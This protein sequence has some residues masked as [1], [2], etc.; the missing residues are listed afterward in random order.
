MPLFISDKEGQWAP[1]HAW[2]SCLLILLKENPVY[3]AH[4]ALEKKI[5]ICK[6]IIF[7]DCNW[8]WQFREN[9]NPEKKEDKQK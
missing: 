1:R 8:T 6:Y 3:I 2:P 4:F 5:Y 9:K 7:L